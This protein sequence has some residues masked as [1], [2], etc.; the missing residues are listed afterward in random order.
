[1]PARSSRLSKCAMIVKTFMRPSWLAIASAKTARAGCGAADDG[2]EA[3]G[4]CGAAGDG[5][6]QDQG[7]GCFDVHE[8]QLPLSDGGRWAY[9]FGFAASSRWLRPK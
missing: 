7:A 1:M 3:E 9:G 4:V 5:S 2:C 6:G 8:G